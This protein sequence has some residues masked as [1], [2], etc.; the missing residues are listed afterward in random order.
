MAAP[1]K[2]VS[3]PVLYRRPCFVVSDCERV[4]PAPMLEICL[5]FRR[6]HEQ[7]LLYLCVT[8]QSLLRAAG[9]TRPAS[10]QGSRAAYYVKRA[11]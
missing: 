7:K 11:A 4:R 10:S 3:V 6:F 8:G 1:S 2:T 5:R 9:T